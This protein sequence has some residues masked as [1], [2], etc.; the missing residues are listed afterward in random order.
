MAKKA[1]CAAIVGLR[2]KKTRPPTHFTCGSYVVWELDFYLGNL[3][4]SLLED[5]EKEEDHLEGV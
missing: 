4:Q 1:S 3:I 2:G 5:L